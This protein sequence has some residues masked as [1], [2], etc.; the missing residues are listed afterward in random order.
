MLRAQTSP[1][2]GGLVLGAQPVM[3]PIISSSPH[4]VLKA[5]AVLQSLFTRLG[6][7]HHPELWLHGDLNHTG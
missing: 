6:G 4:E 3:N 5:P 1:V 7:Y 2:P